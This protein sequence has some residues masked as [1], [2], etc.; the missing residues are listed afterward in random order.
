MET[1]RAVFGLAVCLTFAATSADAALITFNGLGLN[2]QDPVTVDGFVFDYIEND[3]WAIGEPSQISNDVG[4]GTDFITCRD[5]A[6]GEC[7]ITMTPVGG[8]TF[9]LGSFDGAD[10]L[11]GVGGRT[12]QVTGSL[13]GGG[14]VVQ[15]FFTVADLFT[16]Y[17]LSGAFVDLVS[18]EFRGFGPG[19][20]MMALDNIN[21]EASAVP[22]PTTMAL[23]GAGLAALGHRRRRRGARG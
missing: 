12:I 2:T 23:L 19:D 18:V 11:F 22:E 5:T 21:T 4:N 8:G 7:G 17:S 1:R 14:T 3:G 6:D 15:S 20:D 16:S 13:S 9:S 10:G